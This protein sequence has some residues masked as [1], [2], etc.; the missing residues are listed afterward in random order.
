MPATLGPWARHA[1]R[2]SPTRA[3]MTRSFAGAALLA[4]LLAAGAA[5][6]RNSTASTPAEIA[7][8]SGGGQF[9][10]AGTVLPDSVVVSVT[11]DA[12]EPVQGVEVQFEV[13]S[14]GGFLYPDIG[15]T[16]ARGLARTEWRLGTTAAEP[17]QM[18]VRAITAGGR[19]AATAT[20]TAV[21]Q[22]RAPTRVEAVSGQAQS[23]APGSAL[24]DSLAARV[25][26]QFGNPVA[27]ASVR[28]VVPEHAG[29]IAPAVGITGADGITRAQ[30]ALGTIS[31]RH[32]AQAVVEG[33]VPADFTVTATSGISLVIRRPRPNRSYGDRLRVEVVATSAL[34]RIARIT[35]RVDEREA[36]LDLS[37]I[38]FVNVAG[39]PEGNTEL[40]VTVVT[41]EG[42]SAVFVRA[43]ELDHQ[44]Q[45]TVDGPSRGTVIRDGTTAIRA[46]C[47]DQSGCSRV[48]VYAA[49]TADADRDRWTLVAEGV[50]RFSGAVSLDAFNGQEVV[51][52]VQATDATGRRNQERV[53]PV[54][55]ENTPAWTEVASGG[56]RAWDVDATRF[57]YEVDVRGRPAVL[58]RPRGGGPAAVVWPGVWGVDV[59]HA[60][61]SG[62]GAIVGSSE[63]IYEWRGSTRQL[64]T[65]F[66]SGGTLRVSRNWAVWNE[67][68]SL[69]RRDLATGTTR[70]VSRDAQP[71]GN[72]VASNGDV[73][74]ARVSDGEVVLWRNGASTPISAGLGGSSPVTDGTQVVWKA[75]GSTYLRRGAAPERLGTVEHASG[76][77]AFYL[78]NL[79]WA[80]YVNLDAGGTGH[81][82]TVAPDGTRQRASNG[83]D[84]RIVALGPDGTVVYATTGSVPRRFVVTPPYTGQPVDVGGAVGDM[85]FIGGE[86][87]AFV[88]QSAFRVR[89]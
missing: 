74:F 81:V 67:W 69:F 86:L 57:L 35:A 89:Y 16:D 51:L 56:V 75:G 44:P 77:P 76:P 63:G 28:W 8:A 52:M 39:L 7:V 33:A 50:T 85:R 36:V 71:T 80:A 83:A 82:W 47:A 9:A 41:A 87:Y 66:L 72:H 79:G 27:G 64:S 2:L 59:V 42:D 61:L 49:S 53:G 88:G 13:L 3:I 54:F 37:G 25:L 45:L 65:Y 58:A 6:D 34:G 31:G 62:G 70:R 48:A 19:V 22:A 60:R 20:V 1:A 14:G 10:P 73:A 68:R 84:S 26:D 12:G 43:F 23:A 32:V 17:Q 15:T 18:E 38:G 24:P 55:V 11:N 21:A 4:T 46:E 5:C 40:W 78:A 29:T 30:W